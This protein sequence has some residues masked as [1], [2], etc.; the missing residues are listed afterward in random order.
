MLLIIG[1]QN[2]TRC[3]MTKAILEKKYIKYEY[4]LD[5]ELPKDILHKYMKKAQ[6]AGLMSFPLIIKDE[7]IIKLEDAVK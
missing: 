3:N 5:S 2:C 1:T 6:W 7:E 4:K